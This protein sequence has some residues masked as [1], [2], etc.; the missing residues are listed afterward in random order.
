MET[1]AGMDRALENAQ[2]SDVP[3]ANVLR[4]TR[5]T[6]VEGAIGQ[7]ADQFAPPHINFYKREGEQ[8]IFSVPYSAD[9]VD[10][11]FFNGGVKEKP[12]FSPEELAEVREQ[13]KARVQNLTGV[14]D[15]LVAQFTAALDRE[16]AVDKIN[17]IDEQLYKLEH[18]VANRSRENVDTPPARPGTLLSAAE[19][20]RRTLMARL[21]KLDIERKEKRLSE[22]S[23]W[24]IRHLR[25]SIAES[26]TLSEEAARKLLE[27]VEQG[28]KQL[29][30]LVTGDPTPNKEP[31]SASEMLELEQELARALRGETDPV[32]PGNEAV[33][34]ENPFAS[35]PNRIRDDGRSSPDA[36]PDR[37]RAHVEILPLARVR[38][39]F[40]KNMREGMEL[41]PCLWA[42]F[43]HLAS[44]QERSALC[45]EVVDAGEAAGYVWSTFNNYPHPTETARADRE[46]RPERRG[47][48]ERDRGERAERI[49]FAQAKK[50]FEDADSGTI[51]DFDELK[52]LYEEVTDA[53]R[54]KDK[55]DLRT[56][57]LKQGAWLNQEL[58]KKVLDESDAAKAESKEAPRESDAAKEAQRQSALAEIQA[59]IQA[60]RE[61]RAKLN[62]T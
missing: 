17:E 2:K 55:P 21:T 3:P 27:K 44:K 8:P 10:K 41:G 15:E 60:I 25:K 12:P 52:R 38:A 6:R 32:P 53:L 18:P 56:W 46:A 1:D 5:F 16:S 24:A 30:N 58:V 47:R 49:T 9:A 19:V 7:E 36:N 22:D 50:R 13:L 59:R 34:E 51:E 40:W 28:I 26:P 4:A 14:T 43:D 39:L 31:E 29:E 23:T 54:P 37:L 20:E 62:S 11:Y 48:D 45:Q 57:L 61:R 35:A 42:A 33:T